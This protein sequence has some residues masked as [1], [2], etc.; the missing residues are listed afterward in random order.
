[1]MLYK[2][3][4]CLSLFTDPRVLS[5]EQNLD[6]ENGIETREVASCPW[7]GCEWFDEVEEGE[8]G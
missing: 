5:F 2:C 7:C 8:D 3:D 1:M 4:S 6:D